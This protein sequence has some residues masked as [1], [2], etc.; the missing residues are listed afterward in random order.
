MTFLFLE[1]PCYFEFLDTFF[2]IT[3]PKPSSLL[4]PQLNQSND[5]IPVLLPFCEH[6]LG[7]DLRTLSEIKR[8]KAADSTAKPVARTNL[9][10]SHSFT[11]VRSSSLKP[12]RQPDKKLR[13]DSDGA[14][15]RVSSLNDLQRSVLGVFLFCEMN[16]LC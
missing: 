15:K 6:F 2:I 10:R 4:Q 5:F 16:F 13:N 9:F 7:A 8:R 14:V 1:D 3:C 12:S 11:D